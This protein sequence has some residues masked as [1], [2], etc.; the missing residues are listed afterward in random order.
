MKSGCNDYD[1]ASR[2]GRGKVFPVWEKR[3]LFV[4]N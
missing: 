2:E 1:I 4:N 3:Q